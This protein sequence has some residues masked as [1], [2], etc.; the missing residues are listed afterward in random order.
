MLLKTKFWFL[1]YKVDSKK[2]SRV[3]YSRV[4]NKVFALNANIFLVAWIQNCRTLSRNKHMTFSE[5]IV[6]FTIII[7]TSGDVGTTE[8]NQV[9]IQNY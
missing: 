8:E 5:L 6:I 7:S 1:S 2:I 4:Q 9:F 3:S